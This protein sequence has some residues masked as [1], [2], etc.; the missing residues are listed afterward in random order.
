MRIAIVGAGLAGLACAHELERLG[1]APEIF[2]KGGCVGDRF[3]ATETMAQFMHVNPRQDILTYLHEELLLPVRPDYA[4]S[5]FVAHSATHE[6]EISG[7][8]GYVTIR[9]R[10]DRSLERQL[11][12]HVSARIHFRSAPDVEDL[13]R[14]Y[15][16]VVVATGDQ[17]WTN[18]LASWQPDL[19]WGGQGA[20]VRGHFT[21][22]ELHFFFNTRYAGTGYAQLTPVD[23]RTAI[24]GVGVPNATETTLD[25]YWERFRSD[26]GYRWDA[27]ES[28]F[29]LIK[30]TCG[31]VR[32]VVSGN[33][34]LVGVAGGFLESL[35][36]T[37]Q[38]PS[39]SS[40]VMAARQIAL[41]DRSLDRFA[42]RWRVYYNQVDRIRRNVNAWTDEEM[43]HMVLALRMGGNLLARSP[44]NLLAPGAA[45]LD[46]LRLADD[47]SPEI[48]LS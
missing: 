35:G 21:P 36:L 24:A 18:R 45:V 16:Q 29:R 27:E 44:W 19:A 25:E 33:V 7:Q 10:D 15:D 46:M 38:C 2:E 26:Q 37:G 1:F 39:L 3:V 48:G 11:A 13:R 30:Y 14:E 6:A 41:N 12:R 17:S 20:L 4:V 8:L 28:P 32:P 23:E 47:P 42:R 9:G 43:D 40:G 31:Q 34:L 5:R 22:G